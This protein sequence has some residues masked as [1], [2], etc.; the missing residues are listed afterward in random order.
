MAVFS[1]LS[2]RLLLALGVTALLALI[3]RLAGF[4]PPVPKRFVEVPAP[5]P[6]NGALTLADCI[7]FDRD[8]QSWAV[9]RRCTHLACTVNYHEVDN[10]VECP[11]HQSRFTVNGQVLRGPASRPLRR[12]AVTRQDNP[13]RYIITVDG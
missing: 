7:V 2:R 6:T 8:G 9:S 4:Q 12:Y 13:P 1:T 3:A 11:C 10:L 5:L